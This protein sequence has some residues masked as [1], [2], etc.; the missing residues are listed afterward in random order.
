M[1]IVRVTLATGRSQAQKQA[2]ADEITDAL[3]RHGNAHRDH[4]YVLFED[5]DPDAWMVAGET[6]TN[7][8]RKRGEL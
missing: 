7:R 4:V 8:M 3:V 2:M 6:I 5:V 1:P